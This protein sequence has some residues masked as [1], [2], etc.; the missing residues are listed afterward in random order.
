VVLIFIHSFFAMSNKI[1]T[2]YQIKEIYRLLSAGN[3]QRMVSES[4]G[5][6][7]NTVKS[8]LDVL[9][10]A[11]ITV[12]EICDLPE[13]E[14]MVIVASIKS[15]ATP[16]QDMRY[17]QLAALFTY[18]EKELKCTGVTLLILWQE[19]K[20]KQIDGYAYVQFCFHYNNYCKRNKASLHFEHIMGDCLMIDYAGDT[21]SYIDEQTGEIIAC[22]VLVTVLPYSGYTFAIAMHSQT[23]VDFIHGMNICLAFLGG[24]PKNILSDNLKTVVTKSDRYEPKFSDLAL[25]F[26]SH[27]KSN[28]L[29]T[30]PAKPTD[31][32]MVENAVKNVYRKI[33]A[34]L[35]NENF[36]SLSEIN[37]GMRKQL[38]ILN[39]TAFQGK[40][41][42]RADLFIE[43]KNT[44][45]ALPAQP[46]EPY[47]IKKA[48]VQRNYH[49]EINNQF[50]SV[51]YLFVGKEVQVYYNATTIEIYIKERERIALHTK[52]NTTYGYCTA[53]NHMPPNHSG[54]LASRGWDA[55]YFRKKASDIGPCTLAFIEKILMS[56][57][58][59][60]QTYLSCMGLFRLE[61]TYSALRLEQ[62]CKRLEN[63]SQV[64]YKKV[65]EVLQKNLDQ[66]TYNPLEVKSPILHPNLRSN[67]K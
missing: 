49:I 40:K 53:P 35:R 25:Q 43:E 8:Y 23:Q 7:R 30:R 63:V 13:D 52:M 22:Q 54:H 46:F 9:Q 29:A 41:Y 14:V 60:E 57:T 58:Y 3:S 36:T 59:V 48:K 32:G 55:D 42:S 11:G 37:E 26:A 33:Y 24:A 5:I 66:Q 67:Y 34:P 6:S 17:K 2:M 61:R 47:K 20:R 28:L 56:K 19:Y 21:I 51:P 1:L 39:H 62:A 50:Y 31:K 38:A 12:S 64:S 65:E 27:Y 18:I 4:L 44:L 10:K 45:L 15:Q 16:L